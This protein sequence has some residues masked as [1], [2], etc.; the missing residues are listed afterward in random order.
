MSTYRELD[1][2]HKQANASNIPVDGNIPQAKAIEIA[3]S[4]GMDT[5]SA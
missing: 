2:W 5:F 4:Y 3:A 1:T